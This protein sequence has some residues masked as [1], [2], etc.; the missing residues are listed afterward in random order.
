[1]T[2]DTGT[3]FGVRKE[4]LTP[5][6][7][8][9]RMGIT[10]AD[11]REGMET[12]LPWK[13]RWTGT[14]VKACF[15]Y[16]RFLEFVS[17]HY[18]LFGTAAG[19]AAIQAAFLKT[20]VTDPIKTH[21]R[22]AV[23][24][25]KE[26]DIFRDTNGWIYK[27][28]SRLL[29]DLCGRCMTEGVFDVAKA[30]WLAGTAEG[31]KIL[32][33]Y[34]D[35]FAQLEHTYN[36]LGRTRL[37]A[38]KEMLKNI[39]I[40]IT[41]APLYGEDL[42]YTSEK[43]ND[44]FD[45]AAYLELSR[46][47]IEN[48]Y[49]LRAFDPKEYSETATG[50]RIGFSPYKIV[51]GSQLYSVRLRHYPLPGG[52][53]ANGKVLYLST[54]LINKPELFDLAQGKSLIEAL[55]RIGYDIYLVDYGD[56]TPEM[57]SLDFGFFGKEVHDRYLELIKREH[58]R[59]SIY[60]IGY[61]MGGTIMLPYLARRVEERFRRGKRMDITKLALIASPVRFDDGESGHG[62]M[63][64]FIRENYDPYLM[65]ELYGSV[66]VPPQAIDF[67]MNEIQPGVNYTVLS[68][69]YSRAA[70]PGA[71]EDAAPF[72]Y[73]LTHGTKFPA[74]AHQEWIGQFFLGNALVEGTYCLPSSVPELDGEPVDMDALRRGGVRIFDYRGLRDPIAPPGSCVASELWGQVQKG[75][76]SLTRGG[77]NR[78]IEKNIG[79]IFVVSKKLLAEYVEILA[80]FL[81]D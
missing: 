15:H 30:R 19:L 58:P 9:T 14:Q 13:S 1:M 76:V 38:M 71:V 62:P 56:C 29:Y 8:L 16:K 10:P 61:C 51:D 34:I 47:R 25:G 5:S 63:R 40:C 35:E 24:A 81:G 66:N 60:V 55:H 59:K 54:P 77:L 50:N 67:G 18:L 70:F 11:N 52:I 42:P 41:E 79:H 31:R 75:N 23:R 65:N 53:K 68:G 45:F 39:L 21:V 2:T 32:E 3:D 26:P 80:A 72:L 28:Y 4:G 69:F 73:W 74:R 46:R 36:A 22:L 64:A 20:F 33:D 43:A 57:A 78:T 49:R 48:L 17:R 6:V 37:A 7:L 44:G 27:N 12:A